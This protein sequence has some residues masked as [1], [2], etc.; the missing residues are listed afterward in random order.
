LQL[1]GP[2]VDSGTYDY[3]TKAIVGTE[4]SSRGDFAPNED[5]NVLVH[6]VSSTEGALGYFGYAYYAENK[7]KLKLVPIED[8][9]AD[10]GE[11]PILPT[12]ETVANGT[13]QPLSRPIFIYVSTK[14]MD[15][16]EVTA[17]VDFYLKEGRALVAEVGYIPLPDTAYELVEKRFAAKTTG[18]LF[19]DGSK[20]GATITEMLTEK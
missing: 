11:G 13:Y 4:H 2:G 18:S 3:F 16:P 6:G 1:L 15:R 9:K 12:P 8:G 19:E 17:F 20:I 7:D 14:A 10:N 5:D